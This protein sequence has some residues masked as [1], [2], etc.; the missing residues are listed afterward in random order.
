MAMRLAAAA[1]AMSP[2]C[3][4]ADDVAPQWTRM[5]EFYV[6]NDAAVSRGDIFVN[7]HTG[8][9]LP[10]ACSAGKWCTVEVG[11]L[12]IPG[13]AK[14]VF[15]VGIMIITHGKAA[16]TADLNIAFRAYPADDQPADAGYIGQATETSPGGGVR[17]NLAT[18]APVREGKF[19]FKYGKS[20]KGDWPANSSYGLNLTIQAW[21][22]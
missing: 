16:E 11:K 15:L 12:G 10:E 7:T 13:D 22:R 17:S 4:M 9:H 2:L 19:Q 21:A 5:S 3:A 6:R 1:L 14:A 20:T 8:E 18:W